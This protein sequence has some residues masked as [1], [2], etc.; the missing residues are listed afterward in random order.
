MTS[1]PPDSSDVMS[2]ERSFRSEDDVRLSDIWAAMVRRKLVIAALV[3]VS[4]TFGLVYA[5][6]TPRVY[7]Y[8]T[9]IEIG[10]RYTVSRNEL[11]DRFELI[12]PIETV[13]AKVAGGYIAQALRE[14]VKQTDDTRR[15]NVKVEVPKNSQILILESTGTAENEAT[16]VALHE[17]IVDRLRLD[18]LRVQ[19]ALRKDLETRFE[20]QQRSLAE[21]RHQA[22]LFDVQLK[23]LEGNAELPTRE[24]SYLTSLRLADNQRAQAEMIVLIDN[25]RLQ[26]A[27]MRETRTAVSPM[28]SFDPVGLGRGMSVVFAVLVG[29]ILGVVVALF[30]DF[31]AKARERDARPTPAA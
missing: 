6:V 18:H 28:R 17:A 5:F 26:L 9:M 16:Y 14:H 27:N 13:R 24:L 1:L 21:L 3:I 30:V 25:V 2:Y 31:A 8:T 19:E 23:R 11:N 4:A 7:E 29:L 10:T 15:Y 20:M 22:N 12:E